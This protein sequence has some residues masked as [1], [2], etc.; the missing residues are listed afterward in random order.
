MKA[1]AGQPASRIA[2]PSVRSE[3]IINAPHLARGY[4]PMAADRIHLTDLRDYIHLMA[5]WPT[6]VIVRASAGLREVSL[7]RRPGSFRGNRC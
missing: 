1:V 3:S 4:A 2:S 6:A 5:C 7:A